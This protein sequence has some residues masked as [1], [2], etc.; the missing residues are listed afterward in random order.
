MML[1]GHGGG[2]QRFGLQRTYGVRAEAGDFRDH[3]QINIQR[4]HAGGAFG[5]SLLLTFQGD[6]LT[7]GRHETF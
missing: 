7:F 3:D 1:G 4:E 5:L 2:R 6:P